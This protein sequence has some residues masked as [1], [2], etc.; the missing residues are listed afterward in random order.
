M[1]PKGGDAAQEGVRAGRDVGA[2]RA[3][4]VRRHLQDVNRLTEQCED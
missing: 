2:A 4:S 3:Q 1:A